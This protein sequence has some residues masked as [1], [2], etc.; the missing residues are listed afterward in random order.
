META[1][2]IFEQRIVKNEETLKQKELNQDKILLYL[3]LFE[4]P[5]SIKTEQVRAKQ[6]TLQLLKMEARMLKAMA[7]DDQEREQVL[8][9]F[10]QRQH[11]IS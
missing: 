7:A 6:R 3:S 5:I 1:T 10:T 4:R 9:D 11:L 2:E 8:A